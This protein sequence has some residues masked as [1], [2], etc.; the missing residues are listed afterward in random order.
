[1]INDEWNSKSV[2]E[3][4]DIIKEHV[5]LATSKPFDFSPPKEFTYGLY[6]FKLINIKNGQAY[7]DVQITS[8]NSLDYIDISND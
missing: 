6:N 7:Y 5:K 2:E 8:K 3:L 1:M 4:I